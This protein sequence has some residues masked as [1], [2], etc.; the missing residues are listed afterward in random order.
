MN[1]EVPFYTVSHYIHGKTHTVTGEEKH[2]I[3]HPATGKII[4]ETYLAN[5]KTL[6]AAVNSAKKAFSEW[7]DTP[8][9]KR[10]RILF[11]FKEL[12][13]KNKASLAALVSREHGKTLDD[14]AG[15]ID[16]GIELIEFMCS[17]P[18][19]LRGTFSENAGSHIDCYTIRQPLG[20]C[21]GI[22]PFNFP[23]MVPLWMMIPAI[24]CGN[25]F[26]LKPSEQDP[27][28]PLKL[29][30]L[31]TE[32]GLP[33]GVINIINGD[34]SIV[35]QVLCHPDI[36]AVTAV[37]STPV[38]KHIYKT[39]IA[40]GKRS[41]T[42]GGAKNHCIVMPDADLDIAAD[43][44]AGAAFGAA[45]ERCMA[46]SAVVAVGDTTADKL[47][48]KITQKIEQLHI[49]P[50]DKPNVDMGPLISRTHR[51][52]VM[53]YIELGIQEGAQ[54]VVDG[55]KTVFP[56]HPEGFFLGASLFDKVQPHMR[57]YQEEI[58][59]PVLCLIRAANF[60]EGLAL[61]NHHIYGNGTA[62][63]TQNGET[64]R[65]FANKVQAGMVGINIPIPVPVTFHPFG[66]WK[67]SLFGD[68]GMHGD[69]SIQFYTQTKTVTVKWPHTSHANSSYIMPND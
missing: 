46:I 14:A 30:E 42:F 45:G 61:I 25:T 8:P 32:A 64:A 37:A 36:K 55:R 33:E 22:S 50:G 49:G 67:S 66:G 63:F 11:H 15:S 7:A 29:A 34:K 21:A 62:I 13:Q 2:A 19:L 5:T 43:A 69:Q 60:E 68:L 27:S 47:I 56:E 16:R 58:F 4:G 18:Y 1:Q 20:I 40:N 9:L 65:T 3:T 52:K 57:I 54:L 26:I 28:A 38:A 35:E 53:N 17:A 41:H 10:A 59:G 12:L 31:L 23:V 39:A 51:E 24:A 48:E 44:I 6:D